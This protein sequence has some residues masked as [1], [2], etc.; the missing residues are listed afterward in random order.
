VR[1]GRA[2]QADA[3]PTGKPWVDANGWIV[4]LARA[5]EPAREVWLDFAPPAMARPEGYL[6]AAAEAEAYGAHWILPSA[7]PNNDALVAALEYFADHADWRDW[8]TVAALGVVSDFRGANHFLATEFLNLAARRPLP[9]RIL[10]SPPEPGSLRAIVVVEAGT[11]SD[12]WRR[13]TTRFAEAGGLVIAPAGFFTATSGEMRLGYHTRQVGRG[14]IAQPAAKWVDPY[15]LV[16]DA[17]FLLG[18]EHDVFR[19]YNATSMNCHYAASA[20]GRRA[21]AH[22]LNYSLRPGSHPV[23]LATARRYRSARLY[24]LESPKAAAVAVE[25]TRYGAEV[26]LPPFG[27]Y[28]AIELES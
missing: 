27:P 24:T 21:V 11:I 26:G 23:T 4:E 17:H 25:S 20:D 14:E 3:G 22:L 15:L 10:A 19:L 6:L 7:S 18:R 16:N 13:K 9:C 28:A 5:L 1:T 2:A 12:D 8:E